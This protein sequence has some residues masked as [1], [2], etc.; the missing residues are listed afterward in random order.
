MFKKL[1]QISIISLAFCFNQAYGATLENMIGQKLMVGFHGNSHSRQFKTVLK[2]IK[3]G[4]VGGVIIFKH[5]F[6][7][8]KELLELTDK[9][10]NSKAPCKPFIAVDEE[11]GVIQILN[12][13][14]G[15]K[16]FISAK[17]IVLLNDNVAHT[18][19]S[20]MAKI[21]KEAGFN[22]NFAPTVD[23]NL[24]KD[25]IINKKERSFSAD[26]NVVNKYASIVIE[27]HFREKI[28]TSIK[29]FP[30]H[31]SLASDTHKGFSDASNSWDVI[32]LEP[33]KK[34][35]NKNNLQT[36]M[37]SHVF[38]NK[39]DSNYPAS[40]SENTIKKLLREEI[41]FNG[42]V[43][44]DDLQ[45]GAIKNNYSLDE[46]II[47]TSKASADILLFAN[48]FEPDMKIPKKAVKIIKKA[49]EN[50]EITEEEIE[51]SYN[52]IIEL[53]NNL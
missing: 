5:N 20:N 3:R 25:S 13:K 38:I 51:K 1:A 17:K 37:V 6:K 36:V 7:N 35:I 41:G 27:E 44:T 49:I 22:I 47:Q 33:Y 19:Y 26:P 16:N 18:Q 30:G 12:A 14:N 32:E 50:G 21:L 29:H 43:V 45:M 42:V 40:M 31:G 52:R 28:I 8:K 9:I 4:E 46:T 10:N 34:L 23:L 2:Q 15:F 11:G 39:I 53:K 24:N 48:F